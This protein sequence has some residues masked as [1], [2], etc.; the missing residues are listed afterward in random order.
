EVELTCAPGAWDGVDE[1]GK[2]YL[3]ARTMRIRGRGRSSAQVRET[4]VLLPGPGG[5][6]EAGEQALR[7]EVARGWRGEHGDVHRAA[8][9]PR[10][11][12]VRCG[13][14]LRWTVPLGRRPKARV[15]PQS[16][17]RPMRSGLPGWWWG[18]VRI[19][20]WPP[21]AWLRVFRCTIRRRCSRPAGSWPA[22]RWRGATVFAGECVGGK[23]RLPARIWR[24]WRSTRHG[25]RDCSSR[26]PRRWKSWWS[27][28]T[29][30]VPEW[31]PP[32]RTVRWPT[33]AMS[34][35]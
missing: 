5:R 19:G 12:G 33:S 13:R 2:G 18:G 1:F 3:S 17:V 29:W 9:R 26:W 21:R 32:R 24:C 30:C 10:E 22:R 4:T 23:R 27:G 31:W 14:N 15:S 35:G 8:A 28:W 11:A 6:V 7:L 20:R 16:P 25:T 34:I